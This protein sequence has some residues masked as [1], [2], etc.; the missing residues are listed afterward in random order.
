M[1]NIFMVSVAPHE[2]R[3][4]LSVQQSF[5]APGRPNKNKHF[6]I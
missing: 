2:E 6:E 3:Y 4:T 1:R 5:V